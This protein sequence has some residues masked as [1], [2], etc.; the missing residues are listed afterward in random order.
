LNRAERRRQAKGASL[1]GEIARFQILDDAGLIDAMGR[2]PAV[3]SGLNA[4]LDAF[5]GD[6][7]PRCGAC[8]GVLSWAS[9]P[10]AWAVLLSQREASVCG[11]CLTC[12]EANPTT[13]P[14]VI[15]ARLGAR[16]LD[17]A[18]LNARWGRA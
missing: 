11:L 4:L 6:A 10:Y 18:H 1:Q 13:L 9:P 3:T 16:V 2:S 17:P 12:I 8:G 5:G 14:Q 7:P 15:L